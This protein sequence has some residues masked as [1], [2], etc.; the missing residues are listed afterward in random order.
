MW[1]R[2]QRGS[3]A[4]QGHRGDIVRIKTCV[5]QSR[6]DQRSLCGA[7]RCCQATGAPRLVVG[8]PCTMFN[9]PISQYD[10]VA[11]TM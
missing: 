4:V 11:S 8:R 7:V 9:Q 2:T 5:R 10:L 6:L 1:H 3:S